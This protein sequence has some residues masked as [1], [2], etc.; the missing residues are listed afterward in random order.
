MKNNWLIIIS[1]L[2]L[3]LFTGCKEDEPPFD[4]S[5]DCEVALEQILVEVTAE[6]GHFEVGYE[7]KNATQDAEL[8]VNSEGLK[9]VKNIVVNDSVVA[10][11]VDPSYEKTERTCRIE[12]I[13]PGVYPNPIITVKQSVGKEYS[14]G[15]DLVSVTAT[16]IT[17]DVVP[18]DKDMSY[19]FILGNGEYIKGNGLME[20]DEALW[21]SDLEIFESFAKAFGCEVSDAAKTFM[22]QG[23]MI[24]HQ[25]TEVIPNTEYVAYA[26]G[27]DNKTMKPTTEV[28]RLLIK[29]L[30]VQEYTLHFDFSVKVD[31]PNVV[32][33]VTPQGYD[34]YFYFGVFW[35]KDVPPGTSPEKLRSLCEADW[36]QYKGQY[37]SFFD[38]TEQGLHFI[39]NELAYKGTAHL[40]AE[41]DANT[42]FVLWAF[43]MNDEALLNTVPETYYFETGQVSASDNK[44]TLSID[45]LYSRKAKVKVE[46]TNDDTYIATLVKADRFDRYSDDEIMEYIVDNF[47]LQY[48]SGVMSD[49]ATG[50]I[51]STE[52]ELLVFG[53]QVGVPTTSLQR[54][55]FTTADVVYADLDFSL[56]VGDYYN[57]SEVAAINSNYSAFDGYAIV[58]V[59][60]QVD[61]DAVNFYFNAMSVDEFFNYSYEQL[62][63]GLVAEGPADKKGSYVFEFDDP[64]IFFGVAEDADGNFTEMWTSDEIIFTKNGCSAV[65]NFFDNTEQNAQYKRRLSGRK[66]MAVGAML[67]N[68]Q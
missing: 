56:N 39:F 52:Y 64:Y 1:A 33:D 47:K 53:C 10:F 63:E 26:Y 42:E 14:I 59:E 49:V 36:E 34:G 66:A 3:T 25:I 30:D 15:L 41:L 5:T 16:T 2:F 17:L 23:D 55:K 43:G 45:E 22:Y 18:K 68:E 54:L 58:D 57:G 40:E 4:D 29:T 27:F 60:A 24:S 9:W 7:L 11:D 61:A 51:P 12:L 19:V 37:S 31:G 20:D 48:T 6:G 38:N 62:I 21:E 8:K 50:L 13:Y 65:E 44:F 46:P 32:I 35:A 67:S 28:S